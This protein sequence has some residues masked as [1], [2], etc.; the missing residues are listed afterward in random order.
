MG[1]ERKLKVVLED[2][3]KMVVYYEVGYG[4]VG[5]IIGGGD[6]VYKIIM[7]LRGFVG[8]YILLF[9]EEEKSFYLKKYMLDRIVRYFGG[10]VVE[11]I[12]F[13]K[14]NIIDGV[15]SDIYYVI[16]IVKDI[17]I[18]Y[19]MIEKFGFVFLEVIEEDYMF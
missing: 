5:Y 3:K 16:L 6:R 14:E 8:G 17:V 4:I 1:F 19:G 18:K 7:I 9:L 2:E 10:R 13:G 15:G 11:E 12:I